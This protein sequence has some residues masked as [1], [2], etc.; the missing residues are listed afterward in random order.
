MYHKFIWIALFVFLSFFVFACGN[1][2][3][4]NEDDIGDDNAGDGEVIAGAEVSSYLPDPE[5]QGDN[6]IDDD[7]AD[8][9]G[10]EAFDN[11]DPWEPGDVPV[12]IEIPD[13]EFASLR[14]ELSDPENIGDG[15]LFGGGP[16][17]GELT[18]YVYDDA[19]CTPI[20][21]V[22]IFYGQPT[23]IVFTDDQ[24]KAV[25][26]GEDPPGMITAYKDDFWAWSYQVDA[27]V[28]YFRL[29]PEFVY[30]DYIDSETGS[31]LREGE[32]LDLDNPGIIEAFKTPLFG[33]ITLPGFSRDMIG[34]YNKFLAVDSTFEFGYVHGTRGPYDEDVPT[35]LYLPDLELVLNIPS[36]GELGIWADNEQHNVP[37]LP[38]ATERSLS[39][40]IVSLEVGHLFDF[41][42]LLSV[43]EEIVYG[44]DVFEILLPIIK[45]AINDVIRIAYVGANPDW[46]PS[47]PPDIEL[48]SID[49]ENGSV[50]VKIENPD[51]DYNY[52]N[53]L[54]AEIPNRSMFPLS[55]ALVDD[56]TADMAYVE[57]P[58]ADYIAMAVKTDL[59]T[60]GFASGQIS[61]AVKYAESISE[62][63][64][65]LAIDNAEFAPFFEP[66]L[67]WYDDETGDV[68]WDMQQGDGVDIDLF[69]VIIEPYGSYYR[70]DILMAILPGDA[71]SYHPPNAE[72]GIYPSKYT[73]VVVLALDLPDE[74]LSQGYDP[75]RLLSYNIPA[76]SLW[77]YPDLPE[78]LAYLF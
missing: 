54:G 31:F 58:N 60:T 45:P 33:G 19:D 67:S 9:L 17:A 21:N 39:A 28:M 27:A 47:G 24:G 64:D 59:L 62:W 7:V 10:D 6:P 49:P 46:D 32:L 35:N 25:I 66:A 3:S 5:S 30:N 18:V 63:S 65:G 26:E 23:Q 77:S 70:P 11:N 4:L 29:R 8:D 34:A 73:D 13:I 56:E 61:C 72:M 38:D 44:G 42:S 37:V 15:V 41:D 57:V 74:L 71:R 68:F 1:D 22:K 55:M 51:F 52:L 75:T 50:S 12:D 20:P 78:L 43:I 48:Q 16:Y 14:C 53:V 40:F 69:W 2:D 76:M 36:Y